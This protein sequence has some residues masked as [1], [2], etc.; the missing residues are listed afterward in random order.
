MKYCVLALALFAAPAFAQSGPNATEQEQVSSSTAALLESY[1]LGHL[2]NSDKV[3]IE[4]LLNRALT[5]A[6]NRSAACPTSGVVESKI[7]GEFNGWEGETVYKLENGQVWQQSK[8]KYKYKY[9]YRP[10]V[11]IF[12]DGT[13]WKIQVE[14][15]DEIVEV[16]CID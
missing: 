9:K 10:D 2:S 13:R 6:S 3:K 12:K 8:Y 4:T 1:G 11:L 16:T 5:V 14:G 15:L 7:D